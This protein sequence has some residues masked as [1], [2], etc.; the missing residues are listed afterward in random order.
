MP[1]RLELGI[2]VNNIQNMFVLDNYF[3][4]NSTIYIESI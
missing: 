3:R 4:L 2:I 1:V